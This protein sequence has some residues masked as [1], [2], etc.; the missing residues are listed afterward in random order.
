MCIETIILKIYWL[1]YNVMLKC[2]LPAS[3]LMGNLENL[4]SYM[5]CVTF[6]LDSIALEQSVP[7]ISMVSNIYGVSSRM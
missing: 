4:K 6:L 3:F 5:A 2:I 1:N 7:S